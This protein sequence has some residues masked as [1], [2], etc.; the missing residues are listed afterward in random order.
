MAGP[1]LSSIG[2]SKTREQ[3][4]EAVVKP[5]ATIAEGFDTVVLTTKSGEVHVGTLA[6]EDAA[7]LT[8]RLTDDTRVR[9][10]RADIARRDSAP[11]SMPEIYGAV[12]SKA[13]LRDVIEF[14]SSLRAEPAAAD[15]APE[16][17][18]ALRA[19]PATQTAGGHGE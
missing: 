17:P 15:Q 10:T 7:A 11:S 9:V 18:R 14:L 2:S 3:L 12:L 13:E 8:L 4:L 5:N 1:E 16:L 6:S 19:R